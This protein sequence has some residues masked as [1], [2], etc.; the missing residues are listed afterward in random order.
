MDLG[1]YLDRRI[2]FMTPEWKEMLRHAAA[3][4]DRLGLEM[5]MHSSAGWSE[6][7]GPWVKPEHAMKKYVWSETRIDGPR[8]FSAVLTD[9]ADAG[10]KYFSGIAPYGNDFNAPPAWFAPGSK[11]VLDL[12]RVKEF[13]EV[14]LNGKP[15]GILWKAPSQ[16]EVTEALHPGKN[17]LQIRITNLWPNRIIGEEQPA[18]RQKYTFTAHKVF[19]KDSPLLKSGLLG[20]VTID[21][22]GLP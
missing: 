5:G 10:A 18:A 22:V 1:Q 8:K 16:L 14:S 19:T 13:A 17:H 21:S 11:A 3:E 15:L 7:G 20:P 12:G 2:D 4:C 9:P 6:T